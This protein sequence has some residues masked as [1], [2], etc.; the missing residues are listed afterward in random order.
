MPD[1]PDELG[2]P[3]EVPLSE[4]LGL[5]EPS[6]DGTSLAELERLQ[7]E[8]EH[9]NRGVLALY[10]EL[11]AHARKL[12][13]ADERK[14]DFLALL[15][16]ELRNPLAVAHLA[17]DEL[18]PSPA[19]LILRRQ[20]EHLTRLVDDLLDV[21]R[22]ARGKIALELTPIDLVAL[23]D[24]TVRDRKSLLER[25]GHHVS[26]TRPDRELVIEGDAVRLTQV[27]NNLLHN[28]AKYSPPD[29]TVFID[30]DEADG[31]AVL[32]VRDE[33]RGLTAE[34]R[35]RIFGLFVQAFANGGDEAGGLGIG[36]TLVRQ[37][38]RM[39]GGSVDVESEGRGRG[40]TFLVR[41]P[42]SD[43]QLPTTSRPPA[44]RAEPRAIRR[45][46]LVEDEGDLRVLL[47]AKLRR[48]GLEVTQAVD[49][50]EA[51]AALEAEVPEAVL[52]DL[53]LPG[54]D[55]YEL[56]AE[57]QKRAPGIPLVAL[58][59]YGAPR[60]R[61]RTAAAGFAHHLVKPIAF[62]ALLEVLDEL[63]S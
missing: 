60:D 55:G 7:H 4:E 50:R 52:S 36:L 32:R 49:A 39:Q 47:A 53:G 33:G 54:M 15:A 48:A 43:A 59:G 58:S 61:E 11:E 19:A 9:T 45:V 16:H 63:G 51:L 26:W 41:L 23:V 3:L 30:V 46:L 28:A 37:L 57:V 34:E 10:S 31:G 27:V 2:P 13:R 14:D 5:N 20:V 24:E 22:V 8:L 21:S 17:L 25:T 40:S 35:E 38:I 29:T 62:D 12:K 56:A 18:D 42:L 6:E 44:S 1:E